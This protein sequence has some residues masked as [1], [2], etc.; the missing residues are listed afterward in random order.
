VI[1]V[2]AKANIPE[3]SEAG[4]REDDSASQHSQENHAHI[5]EAIEEARVAMAPLLPGLSISRDRHYQL[6]N[7]IAFA[8]RLASLGVPTVLVYL[9]FTGD[10]GISDVGE[11]FADDAHWQATLGEHVSGVCP[12]TVFENP[13][14]V[15]PARFWLLARSR[16]VLAISPPAIEKRISQ[17]G[18]PALAKDDIWKDENVI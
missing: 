5:G 3:L 17:V 14:D 10:T 13:I 18:L 9:G 8:W 1:L 16:E 12:L 15:G 2:E 6:S 11:P 7:R 4:K